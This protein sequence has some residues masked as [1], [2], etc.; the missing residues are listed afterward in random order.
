[1]CKEW[2]KEHLSSEGV[3]VGWG[4]A[5]REGGLMGS[6]AIY[7]CYPFYA[8]CLIFAMVSVLTECQC[9][10]DL[11]MFTEERCSCHVLCKLV[12]FSSVTGSLWADLS[13][14]N[15]W[16]AILSPFYLVWGLLSWGAMLISVS[17]PSGP[18]RQGSFVSIW[19]GRHDQSS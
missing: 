10:Q 14:K 18:H 4:G 6:L 9:V 2:W 13:T 17:E 11:E 5:G 8:T 15:S 19:K 3:C 16:I 1:M 12:L 7:S